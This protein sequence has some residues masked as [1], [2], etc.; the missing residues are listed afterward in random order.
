MMY[1][2]KDMEA[3]ITSGLPSAQLVYQITDSKAVTTFLMCWITLV[4]T[5]SL[6]GQWV[7]CGRLIWAFARDV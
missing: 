6:F 3:V 4:Y 1:G 7:T 2:M 5:S